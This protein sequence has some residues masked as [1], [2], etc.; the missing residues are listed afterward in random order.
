MYMYVPLSLHLLSNTI[1]R[2][3]YLKVGLRAI[4]DS[5]TLS[6]E[7]QKKVD[8]EMDKILRVSCPPSLTQPSIDCV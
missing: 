6:N 2:K 3:Y 5:H 1:L 8:D 7:L 4:E